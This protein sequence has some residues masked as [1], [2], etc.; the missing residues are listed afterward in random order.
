M[1]PWAAPRVDAVDVLVTSWAS[2]VR[3]HNA[4]PTKSQWIRMKNLSITIYSS[5]MPAAIGS[6]V[7]RPSIGALK[8]LVPPPDSVRSGSIGFDKAGVAGPFNEHA[9]E[10]PPN[11]R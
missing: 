11:M 9:A 8:S 7:G 3:A 1:V 4:I 2:P 10:F 6:E 5:Q